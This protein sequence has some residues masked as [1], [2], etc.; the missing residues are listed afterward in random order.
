MFLCIY[1]DIIALQSAQHSHAPNQP[2]PGD[3]STRPY[4]DSAPPP[5]T[6]EQE[7]GLRELQALREDFTR[8]ICTLM[9]RM[10]DIRALGAEYTQFLYKVQGWMHAH[11]LQHTDD[12]DWTG[13][14]PRQVRRSIQYLYYVIVL[15]LCRF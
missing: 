7:Q 10:C 2:F 5:P 4:Q 9:D 3:H 12:F 11:G 6:P 15:F 1:I 14:T 13:T 8:E